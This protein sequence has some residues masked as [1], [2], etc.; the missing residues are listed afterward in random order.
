[1]RLAANQ[2]SVAIYDGQP[3]MAKKDP[4]QN[5][6]SSVQGHLPGQAHF[7]FNVAA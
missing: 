6:I 5:S 2:N 7:D 3:W 1:M 4:D